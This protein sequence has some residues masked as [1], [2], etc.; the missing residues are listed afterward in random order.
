VVFDVEKRLPAVYRPCGWRVVPGAPGVFPDFLGA[1][2]F[3]GC[4]ERHVLHVHQQRDSLLVAS[5]GE[6]SR[7]LAKDPVKLVVVL[8]CPFVPQSTDLCTASMPGARDPCADH[9][10][11]D[12]PRP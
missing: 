1:D 2:Y 6:K 9:A 12:E 8:G 3:V 7:S 5:L 10:P 11:D 4:G